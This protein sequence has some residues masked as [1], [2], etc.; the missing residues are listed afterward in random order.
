MGLAGIFTAVAVVNAVVMS[1][2]DRRREFT[3]GRMA[4]LTRGQVVA[5]AVV[6]SATVVV[7]GVL[8]GALVAA[9]ALAGIAAGPYGLA[10]LA[11]PWRLL[12][13]IFASALVVVG[14][15]A[16]LT[17]WRATSRRLGTY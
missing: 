4:G 17:A 10:A 12:G 1:T 6:E 3:L 13:L 2:A 5:I 16:A 14:S 15:A 7:V 8:L 11:I 9:A